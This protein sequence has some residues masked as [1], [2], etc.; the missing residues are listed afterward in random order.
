MA[1]K[2]AR[3]VTI[4]RGTT[5]LLLLLTTAAILG[6]TLYASGKAY[7]KVD[8]EPFRE[9]RVLTQKLSEGPMRTETIVALTMPIVLNILLFMP[10]GFFMF[11]LLDRPTRPSFQTYLWTLLLA[12]AFSSLVEAWQYF[13]PTRVTDVND[14]IWNGAGAMVGAIYGHLR[15]RVRVVFE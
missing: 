12:M 2:D 15:R 3:I 10:W 4:H 9:I 1:R 5:F 14:I 8:P 13:L 6:L 7:T 11:L